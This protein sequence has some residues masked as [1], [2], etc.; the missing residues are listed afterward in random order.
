MA[1]TGLSEGSDPVTIDPAHEQF[2]VLDA[3]DHA[4]PAASSLAAIHHHMAHPEVVQCP[5]YPSQ[6]V[7]SLRVP[8][9]ERF[10]VMAK[11][12]GRATDRPTACHG[13][14]QVVVGGHSGRS[15]MD[16]AARRNASN[17]VP[18]FRS[19]VKVNLSR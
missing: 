17:L 5:R 3:Y 1:L 14:C 4:F 19:W 15:G 11:T 9:S 6:P 2:I 8:K 10:M 7:V 18:Y 12:L 16:R 13:I